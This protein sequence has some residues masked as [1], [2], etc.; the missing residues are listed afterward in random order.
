MV[1][2]IRTKSR[3]SVSNSIQLNYIIH[4]HEIKPWPPS[5]SLRSVQSVLL[6]WENGDRNSGSLPSNVGNGKIE[7]NEP[8]KLP[9]FMIREASKKTQNHESFKK[10]Y[11]DFHLYDRTV[12]SQ[13]LGSASIN[14]ADFGI[15][16]EVKSISFQLNCKKSFRSSVQP[17]MY[18]SIQPFD[19]ECSSSSPSSRLSKE[20]SLDKEESESVSHSV[21][22]EDDDL[23]IAS[24]TDDE[25]DDIPSNNLQTIRSASET[26]GGLFSNSDN[27]SNN[28]HMHRVMFG[29]ILL[30]FMFSWSYNIQE[31]C[32]S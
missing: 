3:K 4:V 27:R 11:L 26:I 32:L 13:L 8:F 21:K 22:D 1:L 2:G 20:F 14:F 25:T 7:F 12:K 10:N 17:L 28:C 16:K 9:V 24:F 15:I 30:Q 19:I 6:Q 29:C 5:Q 18:V 31:M 23:E